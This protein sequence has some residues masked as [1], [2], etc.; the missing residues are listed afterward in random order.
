MATQSS[1]WLRHI[2]DGMPKARFQDPTIRQNK[3]GS[4]YIVARVDMI[5]TDGLK[6]KK[7]TFV[8][9][10]STMGKRAA[11][12]EKNSI[13][14]TINRADHIV[15]SQ[16]ELAW[17]VKEYEKNHLSRL[18]FAQQCKFDWAWKKHIKPMF[19]AMTLSQITTKCLQ[20]WF[21][22]NQAQFSKET[23]K[24]LKNVLSGVFE[25]AIAWNMHGDRNPVEGVK[26]FGGKECREKRKLTD[27]QTRQFLAELPY[28][29]RMLCSVC[30][31]C[32]LR[33]SEALALKA[34][35]ID[36]AHG[37]ILIRQSF[38]RGILRAEPKTSK[39]RR[40]IPMGYLA[41][42]LKRILPADKDAWIFKIKTAPKWGRE[43][44]YCRDD[45][46]I[47]QHFLRP[48]AKKL[49]FHYKG[50]GFRALRREA[51]TEIGSVAGIGQAMNAGGHT[52]MDMSLVYTLHDHRKVEAA[53]K[54]FQE[55]I[56]GKPE[57]GVQ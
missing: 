20:E 42:D 31:Y 56:A 6:R 13:M 41:D 4:Y 36:F 45:R 43:A 5:T 32:T 49:E 53:I 30:L 22:G 28:D 51:I 18:S 16:V 33:V 54:G 15:R 10:P 34:E 9:G 12:T 23:R 27:E 39:G 14:T 40:D 29:V 55:R 37:L 8:L 21:N 2:L 25:R 19:G 1:D 48:A 35:H 17:V 57:G 50:F 52:H 47:L 7:K 11:I 46:D 44:G 24:S 26:L 38:Y 3:N